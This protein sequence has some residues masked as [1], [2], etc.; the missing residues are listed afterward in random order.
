MERPTA[1][2]VL[3]I[4]NIVFAVLGV[5]GMLATLAMF[6]PTAG[7]NN[8]ALKLMQESPRYL[9]WLKVTIPIGVLGCLA[10]LA[11][12]IGLLRLKRWARTLSIGYAIYAIVFGIAG[13]VMNFIF[14]FRPLL[15]EAQRSQGPEA[16]GAIGVALGGTVGGC[17]GL[18]FPIVLLAFMVRPKVVAA[19][20]PVAPPAVPAP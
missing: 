10:L 15:E 3:G 19:F 7:S 9:M 4:L 20:R 14:L 18:I 13:V 2:T 16:A 6:S 17:V 12:G 1:V 8:P 11:S 5:F